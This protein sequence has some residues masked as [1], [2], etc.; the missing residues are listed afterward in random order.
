MNCK[1]YA[2]IFGLVCL[3]SGFLMSC[4]SSSTPPLVL[5]VNNAGSLQKLW[6]YTTGSYVNSSPA[7]VNSVVYVSSE[8]GNVY[9]FGLP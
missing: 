3:A 9:A 6:S 7:V 8:D 5:N 1:A 4:G 2:S